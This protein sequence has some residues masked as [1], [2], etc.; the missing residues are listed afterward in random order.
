MKNL[1]HLPQ[2][3]FVLFIISG[4]NQNVVNKDHDEMIQKGLEDMVHQVH[5]Y[6][7][8]IC[9]PKRHNYKL[10]ISISCPEHHLMH[11]L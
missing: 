4:V 6:H 11:I 2:M 5:K 1:Q 7:R 3:L 10:I 8:G 9:K